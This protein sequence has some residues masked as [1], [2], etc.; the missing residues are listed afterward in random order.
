MA[1]FV[2]TPGK[3]GVLTALFDLDG[4][5][6]IRAMLVMTNTTA[7]TDQDV[8]NIADIGTLDEYDGSG[9]GRATLA[10]ETVNEDAANNRAEFDVADFN[11][12]TTVAAGT[13]QAAGMVIYRHVTNDADALL[14]AYIDTGGFPVAG[15]GG[16]FA[17]TVNA[18]GLVQAT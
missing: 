7:D 1:S 15:G 17:V 10:S 3:T 14:L 9:Y 2:Y 11:F 16:A 18:E 12:G 4:T 8:A 6:D 5:H 13:R